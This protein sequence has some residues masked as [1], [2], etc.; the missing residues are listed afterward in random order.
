MTYDS[1]KYGKLLIEVAP[2]AIETEEENERALA[3]I[4]RLMRKN[5]DSLS[6]E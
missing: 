2:G 4:D 6:P 1:E 5:E 3:I